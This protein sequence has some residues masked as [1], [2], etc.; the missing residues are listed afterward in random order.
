MRTLF[1]NPMR[2]FWWLVRPLYIWVAS[3][4]TT[5]KIKQ[6]LELDET[7]PVLYVIPRSSIV[8]MLVLYFHCRKAGLPLPST[9]LSSIG[10]SKGASYLYRKR[11]G[12]FQ[13]R[14]RQGPTKKL[15]SLVQKAQR[16]S[17]FKL[18]IVPVS[19]FWGQNPGKEERSFFKLLFSDDESAGILQ[20]FFIVLA[21][22]RNTV[23]HFG[24]SVAL[25]ELVDEGA[26]Y[27]QTAR[28]LTRILR[29]HFRRKRNQ[30]LGQKLYVREAVISRVCKSRA[31][32]EVIIE[33]SKK[34]G[35]SKRRLQ[36]RSRRY[37]REISADM[38]YSV[39]Q[40]F[41]NFVRW[42]WGKLFD[43][44]EVHNIETVNSLVQ[45]DYEI[46]YVPTHRSHLDYL[47]LNYSVYTAGLPNPHT[48][49]GINLNF[50]PIGWFLRRGG[51][52]FLRRSFSGNKLYTKVFTEYLHYRL[53]H[54][55]PISFFPEGG[56]SRSGRLLNPKLGFLGM[57]TKSFLQDSKRPIAFVPMTLS[58]DKII[59]LASYLKELG[60]SRKRKESFGQFLKARRL[61]KQNYGKSYL[62]FGTPIILSDF[63]CS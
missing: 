48:A 61:L 21:Q 46:V 4:S 45:K 15:V 51:A 38:T 7:A 32:Q 36:S 16:E 43:G 41:K 35:T 17:A 60:G 37:A 9:K 63:L 33:E 20:K 52:F 30:V 11:S 13:T 57:I 40:L 39:I 29:V 26:S 49:A 28:K 22:A 24:Q 31:I 59:E 62:N 55:Y 6:N 18:Q 3:R 5:D 44:V 56:R 58:Y 27:D 14:R 12:I 25:R 10:N 8:D 23:I 34:T 2:Y 1:E 53:T 42:L 47:F 54:G 50:F 19:I